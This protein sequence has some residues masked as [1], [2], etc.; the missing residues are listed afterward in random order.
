[1]FF[2]FR[3]RVNAGDFGS[4]APFLLRDLIVERLAPRTCKMLLEMVISSYLVLYFD[5]ILM[6]HLI[7]KIIVCS[8]F[9]SLKHL[10]CIPQRWICY[11]P[12]LWFLKLSN[13]LAILLVVLLLMRSWMFSLT[14]LC[15]MSSLIPFLTM[16]VANLRCVLVIWPF[17]FFFC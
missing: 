13:F 2:R 15:L 4:E 3:L 11:L 5:F 14:T 16:Q 9:C 12:I 17:F 7:C 8:F 10:L 1:M 6:L